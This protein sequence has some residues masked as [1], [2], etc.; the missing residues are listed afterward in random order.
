MFIG[1][2]NALSFIR[3]GL[4]EPIEFRGDLPEFLLVNARQRDG[5]LILVDRSL[6]I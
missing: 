2:S 3:V 1:V 5:R 6:R 4:A